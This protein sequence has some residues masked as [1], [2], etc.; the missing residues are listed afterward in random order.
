MSIKRSKI[1]RIV[2]V[3]SLAAVMTSTHLGVASA[4][5]QADRV[6]CNGPGTD[7]NKVTVFADSLNGW[8][9]SGEGV[10]DFAPVRLDNI[11]SI[12]AGD[13]N[14]VVNYVSTGP[15]DPNVYTNTLA[16]YECESF[17]PDLWAVTKV[18][19]NLP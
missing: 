12:C 3:A 16:L 13:H 17:S 4:T 9:I 1:T 5:T 14:I 6:A 11:H 10:Y 2:T 15:N 8:C 18:T 7:M 19:R